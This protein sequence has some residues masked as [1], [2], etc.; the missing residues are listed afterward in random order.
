MAINSKNP[1]AAKPKRR[2][3][4]NLGTL[5]PGTP[6]PSWR[7]ALAAADHGTGQIIN[8]GEFWARLGI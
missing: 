5:D 7:H 3:P 4:S 6:H 2:P 1:S 8:A